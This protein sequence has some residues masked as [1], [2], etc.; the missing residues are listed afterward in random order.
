MGVSGSG[1]RKSVIFVKEVLSIQGKRVVLPGKRDVGSRLRLHGMVGRHLMWRIQDGSLAVGPV[2]EWEAVNFGIENLCEM[3]RKR[4]SGINILHLSF[5]IGGLAVMGEC[6][7][8]C[9]ATGI[10][11]QSVSDDMGGM[12]Q[13]EEAFGMRE[14]EKLD[15]LLRNPG[16]SPADRSRLLGRKAAVYAGQRA[17]STAASLYDY[18]LEL[19]QSVP[20]TE[21]ERIGILAEQSRLCKLC[22]DYGAGMEKLYSILRLAGDRYFQDAVEAHIEL[23]NYC[24]LLDN[25]SL[26]KDHLESASGLLSCMR[27]SAGMDDLCFALHNA[28][29]G[30]W[31]ATDADSAFWH[32]DLAEHYARR[33]LD[34]MCVLYQN[35][36]VL[37]TYLEDYAQAE[38]FF[39]KALLL[40]ED[41][42]KRLYVVCNIAELERLK[43]NYDKSLAMYSEILE[44]NAES[45]SD[46]VKMH[47]GISMSDLYAV[48]GDYKD[49]YRLLSTSWELSK[50]GNWSENGEKIIELQRDFERFRMENEKRLYSY[51]SEVAQL[52]LSRKNMLIAL[53]S[54]SLTICIFVVVV[55]WRNFKRMRVRSR[56]LSELLERKISEDKDALQALQGQTEK[57]DRELLSNTISL[58]KANDTISSILSSVESL[59]KQSSDAKES[60]LLSHIAAQIRTLDWGENQWAAFKLYFEQVHPAF[61]SKLNKAYPTLTA[62]ENRICAF[63]VMNLNTK[64]IATLLNRSPRTIDTI[65]FRIRRK[66]GIPKEVSTLSFLLPFTQEQVGK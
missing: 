7:G 31:G 39:Q 34:K 17:Y 27:D 61:F 20:G 19:L 12:S 32:L 18:A 57:K 55:L 42:S 43:G 29:A 44:S 28:Y 16:L 8:L 15:S 64:D 53:I 54:T 60:E 45:A 56:Q 3:T 2:E 40:M 11:P 51:Q 24:M 37:Y 1:I 33:N 25:Y 48:K 66:M 52:E 4:I 65:K 30:Y 63:I 9:H 41:E 23:S 13:G 14:I 59:Q 5:F 35:R 36:A 10:I 22:E 26:A 38:T 47:I 49:A 50:T 58:A 21:K 62:G 6:S 46:L